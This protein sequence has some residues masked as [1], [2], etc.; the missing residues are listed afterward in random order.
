MDKAIEKEF[1]DIINEN[2]QLIWSG[3]PKNGLIFG[4]EDLF[5][6]P[7]SIIWLGF[8]LF[9]II[10]AEQT[11]TFFSLLAIPFIIVGVYLLVVRFYIDK[12]KR[13]K[14]LYGLTNKNIIIKYQNEIKIININSLSNIS[15]E[16]LKNGLGTITFGH[17]HP[18]NNWYKKLG[19]PGLKLVPAFELIPNVK[20]VYN[21]ILKFK[22]YAENDKENS[23][24]VKNTAGNSA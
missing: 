18:Y 23:M 8:I 3:K 5:L 9:F 19:W 16:V 4:V 22:S 13:D 2:E 17:I 7:F 10:I 12:W 1:K 21:L 15:I 6:I 14:T 20:E 11:P 24:T